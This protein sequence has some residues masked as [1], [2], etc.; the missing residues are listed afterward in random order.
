MEILIIH[1][2]KRY[3]HSGQCKKPPSGVKKSSYEYFNLK[4]TDPAGIEPASLG[5]KPKR[6]SSTPWILH[7]FFTSKD[8]KHFLP[9]HYFNDSVCT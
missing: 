3:V 1:N 5:S 9:I 2:N 7:I 4:K 8:I 6:I